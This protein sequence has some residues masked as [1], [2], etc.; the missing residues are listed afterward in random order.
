M[1][2]VGEYREAGI[3]G[4]S[5]PEKKGR[6]RREKERGKGEKERRRRRRRKRRGREERRKEEEAAAAGGAFACARQGEHRAPP[7]DRPIQRDEGRSKGVPPHPQPKPHA[8]AG[9]RE[10]VEP[11]ARHHTAAY[12]IIVPTS[13]VI[14]I[15]A[16]P[17]MLRY[18]DGG[19]TDKHR[20]SSAIGVEKFPE[21]T[22]TGADERGKIDSVCAWAITLS[23]RRRAAP[24]R[25][26]GTPL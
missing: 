17:A 23:Q 18:T 13:S 21:S 12:S 5:W 14:A 7:A 16:R 6:G 22:G 25:T 26:S 8:N 2:V 24:P 9:T 3:A 10:R 11:V 1:R 20:C 19:A 4:E 15:S